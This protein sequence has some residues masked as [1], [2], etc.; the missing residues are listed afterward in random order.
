MYDRD[1]WQHLFEWPVIAAVVLLLVGA[2][3]SVLGMT[4]PRYALARGA[5]SLAA[6]LLL[7][8]TASWLHGQPVEAAVVVVVIGIAWIGGLRWVRASQ[9]SAPTDA[10]RLARLAPDIR[11]VLKQNMREIVA[12]IRELKAVM[13]RD[14]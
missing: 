6:I 5:F 8:K 9:I 13:P 12:E 4:P 2:G 7:A 11:D 14:A 3:P 1:M 10:E